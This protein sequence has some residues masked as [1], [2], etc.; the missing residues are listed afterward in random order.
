MGKTTV[1]LERADDATLFSARNAQ[2]FEV[3]LD[4]ATARPDGVGRGA[5]P[6]QLLLMGLAGCSA[7]DVVS[8]LGKSRQRID[9]FRIEAH[10]D[11]PDGVHPSPFTAMHLHFVLE[12]DLQLDRVDRAIRLSMEKYCSAAAT[13][14]Q[15]ARITASCT[16][17]GTPYDLDDLVLGP[18]RG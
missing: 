13:L 5:G 14:R 17:N 11:R 9:T 7:V 8:I 1:T 16:V 6:M 4:D 18:D 10:G 3:L 2:G 15:A 12:G